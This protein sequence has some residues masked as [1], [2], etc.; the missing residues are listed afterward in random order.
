MHRLGAAYRSCYCNTHLQPPSDCLWQH[1]LLIQLVKSKQKATAA[2][3]FVCVASGAAEAPGLLKPKRL[4]DDYVAH[5]VTC[6][7]ISIRTSS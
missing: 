5:E 1:K 2:F 3:M 6:Q 7:A 4:M